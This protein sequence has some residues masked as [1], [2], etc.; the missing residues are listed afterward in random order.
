MT[1]PHAAAAQALRAHFPGEPDEPLRFWVAGEW[2]SDGTQTFDTFDPTTGQRLFEVHAAGQDAVGHAVEAGHAASARWWRTDGQDRARVLRRIADAIRAKAEPLGLADTLDV[3]RPI[4]DTVVRDVERAA[5]L[6]EFWAGATDR[7]RG[8]HVPVQP[9][10]DNTTTY[11]PYGVVGSITPWNYPLTNAVTKVAPALATGNAVVLKPAEESPLSALLLAACAHEAGLPAGLLNVLTGLGETTGDAVVRHPGIEKITFTGST[12]IGRLIGGIAGESLKSVSLELGGKSANIVFPDADLST[13]V[14]AAVFTAFMNQGQTCT[15]G[16]RLLLHR[17]IHDAFLAAMHRRT[18]HLR[19]GDPLEAETHVG[20]LVS[21]AQ[22]SRVRAYLDIASEEGAHR[23]DLPVEHGPRPDAGNFADPV[24]LTGVNHG[25]RVMREE[26]FGPVLSVAA[27]DSD[28]E[29]LAMAGDAEYGLATAL[30]TRDLS[31]AHRFAGALTSGLVWINTVHSLH[32]GS[33]YGGYKQ[34][35]V[36]LEMGL[37]AIS[38]LMRVKSV[39]TAIE[40]WRSPWPT[41]TGQDEPW[42]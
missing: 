19:V 1:T 15:A 6:L 40:P 26:I 24:V 35:G 8:A 38:Q 39:W 42:D 7:L 41:P 33:P 31:R 28:E 2:C 21:P 20:P 10:L 12:A 11:E 32:P 22:L 14:D 16:T 37:E 29:A 34:S 4:R 13:A 18:R 27:F 3:G 25:M 9:G 23:V 5:R 36:G 17:S 30:W